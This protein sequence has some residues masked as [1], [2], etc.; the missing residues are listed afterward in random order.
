MAEEEKNEVETIED[1]EIMDSDDDAERDTPA[2]FNRNAIETDELELANLPDGEIMD[3]DD[4]EADMPA[5]FNRNAIETDELELAN[6][7]GVQAY[8]ATTLERGLVDQATNAFVKTSKDPQKSKPQSQILDFD[9]QIATGELTPFELLQRNNQEKLQRIKDA[10]AREKT[11]GK[12]KKRK[13][14]PSPSTSTTVSK[15]SRKIKQEVHDDDEEDSTYTPDTEV[16]DEDDDWLEEDESEVKKAPKKK[17][18]N[19]G[20]TLLSKGRD[21]TKKIKDDGNDADYNE[22]IRKYQD[23]ASIESGDSSLGTEDEEYHELENNYK[24]NAAVWNKLYKYQ[25]TGVRW[26]H[27]L[28]EHCVGGILADEMGLGKTVQIALFLRSIAESNVKSR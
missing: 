9:D 3:S 7:P 22:R 25:K 26:L 28:H 2:V 8:S 23:S 14:D 17:G 18:K 16:D 4:A 1:G 12:T 6:L 19:R 11:A 13:S 27:E 10:Y 21:V 15:R 20:K 24:I 5:V